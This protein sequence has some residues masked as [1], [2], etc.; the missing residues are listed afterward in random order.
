M[1]AQRLQLFVAR[2]QPSQRLE[3]AANEGMKVGRHLLFDA[4]LAL[5]DRQLSCQAETV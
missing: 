1:L 4:S 5:N 3:D 2:P